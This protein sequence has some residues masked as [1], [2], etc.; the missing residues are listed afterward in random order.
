MTVSAAS[1]VSTISLARDTANDQPP[2]VS[3]AQICSS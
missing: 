3:A 1:A 2:V